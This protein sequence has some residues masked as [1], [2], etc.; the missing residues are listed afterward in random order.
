VVIND[1][2]VHLRGHL[3]KRNT[4]VTVSL[5]RSRHATRFFVLAFA[6][7]VRRSVTCATQACWC[8]TLLHTSTHPH[9][10]T[11]THMR[12][13]AR[14]THA[15]HTHA[16]ICTHTRTHARTHDTRKTHTH[17]FARTHTRTHAHIYTRIHT[18]THTTGGHREAHRYHHCD[19]GPLLR[20]RPDAGP[21]REAP[22]FEHSTGHTATGE[23][24]LA[25][26]WYSHAHTHTHTYTHIQAHTHIHAHTHVHTQVHTHHIRTHH[27]RTCKRPPPCRGQWLRHTPS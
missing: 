10:G 24:N 25:E 12:T 26:M 17:T 20:G 23:T 14:T 27:R 5:S 9:T 11:Y 3:L 2:P 8:W 16:H 6:C 7:V 21:Q 22:A 18:H 1:A 13:H 19:Q 4:Q 15:K